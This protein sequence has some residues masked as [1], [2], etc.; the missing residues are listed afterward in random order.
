MRTVDSAR[1][2]VTLWPG[3]GE[4][5]VGDYLVT[6]GCGFIGSH[7]VDALLR[8]GDGVRVLD[9]LSSGKRENLAAGARLIV[10]DVRDPAVVRAAIEGADGC[11]HLAAIA[12]VQRGNE[13]WVGTH[14]V[15]LAGAVNVFDAAR[16]AKGG[17]TIPVVYASSA[18]VYGDVT[19]MPLSES[20]PARPI[21]A[22]GADKLG[23][24]LHGRVA[25]LVHG[26]PSVGLRFFNVFGPHQDPKSPYSGVI[27]IFAGRLVAREELTVFGDGGQGRD[28]IYVGDV[29]G[30]LLAGMAKA[31]ARAPEVFNVCT[32][33]ET[34]VRALAA[35]MSELHRV[36]PRIAFGAP[37]AGDIRTSIGN[38][39]KIKAK[40]GF[41]AH[42]SLREGLATTLGWLVKGA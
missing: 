13:D 9:D 25:G 15:N 6:G 16:R 7:L 14:A 28:F 33:R 12:S 31:D 3:I 27:S 11:F 24:E 42:T 29:V 38:P 23:C 17:G 19:E 37:R 2:A 5:G 40:L 21:S 30:A 39:A 34:T 41:E 22:Y 8:R 35:L 20:G 10:G 26:V 1:A 18:A 32:G 36:E 4:I